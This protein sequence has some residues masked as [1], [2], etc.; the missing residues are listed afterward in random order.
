MCDRPSSLIIIVPLI[1]KFSIKDIS[2]SALPSSPLRGTIILLFVALS[3]P[4]KIHTWL[5]LPRLYLRPPF[6]GTSQQ[7]LLQSTLVA[8]DTLITVLWFQIFWSQ[9]L[10]KF[11]NLDGGQ[12]VPWRCRRH[13]LRS[14]RSSC[15]LSLRRSASARSTT[16]VDSRDICTVKGSAGTLLQVVVPRAFLKIMKIFR[17]PYGI[18]SNSNHTLILLHVCTGF[19]LY[20]SPR[21]NMWNSGSNKKCLATC[22][23]TKSDLEG[24]G[25]ERV[26]VL[27]IK[28]TTYIVEWLCYLC[29]S[30]ARL[31]VIP[32]GAFFTLSGDVLAPRIGYVLHLRFTY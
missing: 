25:G 21:S 30:R 31:V 4:P 3:V 13:R 24:G 2:V 11:K 27:V 15:D 9:W 14:G 20:T 5:S 32:Y 1:T 10:T 7:K 17:R 8:L 6:L 29:T 16:G 28:E 26:Q 12:W 22:F 18:L 23:C 19:S